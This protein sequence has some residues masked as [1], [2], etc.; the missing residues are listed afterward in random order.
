[1]KITPVDVAHKEFS[2][3]LFGL[4]SD[5]VMHFLQ[6]I[7]QQLEDLIKERNSFKDIIRE[8]DLALVE[9]KDRDQVLKSTIT[10]ASQMAERMREEA[11]RE[12]QVLIAQ[13]RLKAVEIE[14]GAHQNLK[15]IYNEIN[16]LKKL[17]L[18]YEA[19]MKAMAHA[20]L[21]LLEEGQKYLGFPA[22][23]PQ[24]EQALNNLM[25]QSEPQS[26]SFEHDLSSVTGIS[27]LSIDII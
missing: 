6:E 3:S 18:Q 23:G 14:K 16:R 17:R 13:A 8:K 9:Y 4:N 7:S 10:T 19:N 15:N 22:I 5:E 20:H 26:E 11:E 25:N 1:M 27:P 21:S 24:D 12:T 2:K